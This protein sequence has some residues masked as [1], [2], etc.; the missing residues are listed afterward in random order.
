MKVILHKLFPYAPYLNEY[1]GYEETIPDGSSDEEAL[2][3]TD[4]LR[5]LAERSH[6]EKYPHLYTEDGRPVIVKQVTD[7]PEAD[8]K[9]KAELEVVKNKMIAAKTFGEAE[10]IFKTGGFS[11]NIELKQILNDKKNA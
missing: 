10:E 9:I 5:K 11:F 1:I 7:D 8:A 6:K 2:A 3:A 4:R